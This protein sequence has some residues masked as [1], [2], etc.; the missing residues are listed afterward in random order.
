MINLLECVLIATSS[1]TLLTTVILFV[2]YNVKLKSKNEKKLP[3]ISVF[4]PYYNEQADVLLRSLS[5][6]DSQVYPMKIEIFLIDD[7]SRNG[8][9]KAVEGW[10]K[11]ERNQNYKLIKKAINHGRKGFALDYALEVGNPTGDVYVVVDS[12]TF[13]EPDGIKELVKRLWLDDGYAAVCGYITPNNYRDSFIG[14][15]QYYEHISFYGAVRAAQDKLGCVPV[16]AGAFVAHRASAVKE[17]GGWSEWLVEDIAWCWKAISNRYKTGYAPKAKATTQCPADLNGLFKQR[18]RWARG[19]VEAYI[20][21]WKTHWI[22]GLC[23]TPWFIITAIK[24]MFP[25]GLIL[26]GLIFNIWIPFAICVVNMGINLMLIH[27][28][29]LDY[30]LRKDLKMTQLLKFPVFSM[31]LEHITWVPNLL[32]YLDELLHKKKVWLTR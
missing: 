16:L 32:G 25:S 15:L 24:Y 31:I 5:C 26:L 2:T 21:T 29:T 1:F 14:L 27:Y 11:A 18:R 10:L 8:V 22:A 20:V 3:P 13:I 12:D 4:V 6:L 28:Y 17:L 7:G 30:D 9:T 23:A 19:R